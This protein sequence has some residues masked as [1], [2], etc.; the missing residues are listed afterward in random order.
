MQWYITDFVLEEPES[1][2]LEVEL[3]Y[4]DMFLINKCYIKKY[5]LCWLKKTML[6]NP[7]TS[8]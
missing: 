3:F 1:E 7:C 8:F 5:I 6:G 2:K 4:F